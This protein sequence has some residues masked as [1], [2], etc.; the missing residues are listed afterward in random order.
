[1]LTSGA[2]AVVTDAVRAGVLYD[3]ITF[4]ADTLKD[5]AARWNIKL[6]TV[7]RYKRSLSDARRIVQCD[8]QH[9]PATALERKAVITNPLRKPSAAVLDLTDAAPGE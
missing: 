6:A 4:P 2:P 8:A 7:K 3:L 9:E 1:V 5:V